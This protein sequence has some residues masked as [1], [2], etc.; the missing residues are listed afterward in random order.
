MQGPAGVEACNANSIDCDKCQYN[1]IYILG[2]SF[3]EFAFFPES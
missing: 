2:E 1:T 3:T